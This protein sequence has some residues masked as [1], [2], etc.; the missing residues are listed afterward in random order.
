MLRVDR[1]TS[2]E[3]VKQRTGAKLAE[4][5]RKVIELQRMRP[6]LLQ[7]AS[8]CTGQGPTGRCPMLDALDQQE[9]QG[10]R[11]S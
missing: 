11:I 8:L 9:P 3:E 4:A 1:Q 5:E 7:V 10:R 2:C 6:A